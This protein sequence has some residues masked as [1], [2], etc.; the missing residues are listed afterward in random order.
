MAGD[1]IAD[2]LEKFARAFTPPL[3]GRYVREPAIADERGV[4]RIPPPVADPVGSAIWA[5]A[6]SAA[7]LAFIAAAAGHRRRG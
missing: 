3:D 4:L 6:G 7:V 5:V 2:R 1:H